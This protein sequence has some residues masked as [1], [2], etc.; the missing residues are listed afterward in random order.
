MNPNE[1]QNQ[2][3]T[4]SV[5]RWTT[6]KVPTELREL[7]KR[8]AVKENKVEWQVIMNAVSF[9][10]AQAQKPR[11]KE[12]ASLLDKVSWYITKIATSVGELKANPTQENFERL[13][14]TATQIQERL[15]VD[16][17]TLIRAAEAFI[18]YP[19][20]DSRMELNAALKMLILD[21]IVSKLAKE[22]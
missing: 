16:V 13:K 1:I 15:N 20:P 2:L 12:D 10:Y 17:S 9:Y 21:I 22:G 4:Q 19:D 7:I 3:Q 8:I 6:I 5:K 18:K 11:I 14:R